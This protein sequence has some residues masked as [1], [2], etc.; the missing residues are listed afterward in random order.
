LICWLYCTVLYLL[1][2]CFHHIF[3]MKI[4]LN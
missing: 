4:I 1:Y 3:L 2:Y